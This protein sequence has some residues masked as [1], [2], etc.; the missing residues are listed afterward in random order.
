MVDKEGREN[1]QF[2]NVE[3]RY[4]DKY[5]FEK[6]RTSVLQDL[7]TV[8][9]SNTRLLKLTALQIESPGKLR[10]QFRP[11]YRNFKSGQLNIEDGKFPENVFF[12]ISIDWSSGK[13]FG[14][15]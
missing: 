13:F 14:L 2:G 10:K 8:K 4:G 15:K 6:E 12:D 3:S 9:P 1:I 5:E 11:A 7:L